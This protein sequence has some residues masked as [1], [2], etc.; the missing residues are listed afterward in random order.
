[1]SIALPAPPLQLLSHFHVGVEMHHGL[2]ERVVLVTGGAGQLGRHVV[3]RLLRQQTR[4][5]VPVFLEDEEA[6]LTEF[7]GELGARVQFHPDADLTDPD[8]VDAV[9]AGVQAGEGRGPDTLV[10]LAGGFW[11]GPV[12]AT[13][14]DIWD[15]MWRMNTTTAFLC[16]RAVFPSMKAEGWGRI[17]NVSAFPAIDRGKSLLSA[18]AAAKSGVL[19]LTQTLSREGVS[20]GITVNAILP[21]I[22]DTPANRDAMPDSDTSTWIPPSRIADVVAFLVS[23]QAGIITGAGIPLTLG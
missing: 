16:S 1:M 18:Y 13:D 3:N 23:E 4:V 15:R 11:M 14:P 22:I 21:S 5:H 12:E 20:H 2:P 7:L 8:T 6:A 17:V 10:N 9:V 19:S